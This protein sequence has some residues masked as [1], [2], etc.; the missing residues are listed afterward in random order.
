MSIVEFIFA[1]FGTS[2]Q[3]GFQNRENGM[4]NSTF[5]GPG[6]KTGEPDRESGCYFGILRNSVGDSPVCFLK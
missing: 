2:L 4:R 6:T 3:F 1:V 5:P